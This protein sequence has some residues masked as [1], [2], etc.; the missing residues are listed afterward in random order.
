MARYLRFEKDAT[1]SYGVLEGGLIQPLD[2][3]FGDFRKADR[4][5]VPLS[6]V[7]LLAPVLPTKIIAVGTN[8]NGLFRGANALAPVG[9]RFWTKPSNVLN[10]PEGN[11]ELRA[12][13]PA[14]FHEVELAVVIGK[15]AKQVRSADAFHYVFG[16][17]VCNDVSVGDPSANPPESSPFF[18]HGKVFDGF[19]PL[20]PWIE[21]EIDPADLALECRVNGE[22]RQRDRTSDLKFKIPELI[23]RITDICTLYP[24]DV[25]STG[26]PPGVAP[27]IPGDTIECEVEGIGILRNYV[28]VRPDN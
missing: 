3:A 10:D 4:P 26:S 12:G 24:G 16:Y 22:V 9:P 27:I 1:V 15:V 18:T 25:I 13:V 14:A 2:G 21:T 23:E 17:T 5:K 6:E 8:Y 28:R 7:R 11:I 19:G 20:G